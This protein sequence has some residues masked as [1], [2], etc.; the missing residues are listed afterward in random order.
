MEPFEGRVSAE[1]DVALG[2]SGR[3][4]R[5]GVL[6]AAGAA[7]LL[8]AGVLVAG[9]DRSR[10][11]EDHPVTTTSV[12]ATSRTS[13]P[14]VTITA[15]PTTTTASPP[16]PTSIAMM[17]GTGALVAGVPTGA[18]VEAFSYDGRLIHIDLD[19]GTATAAPGPGDL[20]IGDPYTIWPVTGGVVLT[21]PY[22][23]GQD[24]F[25]PGEVTDPPSPLPRS[26]NQ[27]YPAAD[28]SLLWYVQTGLGSTDEATLVRVADGS[29]VRTIQFPSFVTLLGD[30][31]N[32]K[33]LGFSPG[34]GTYLLVDGSAA[35]QRLSPNP[36]LA[37]N[38]TYLVDLSCD[39][40]LV[41]VWHRIVRATGKADASGVLDPN[42]PGFE[43]GGGRLSLSGRYAA[44]VA[45]DGSIHIIDLTTSHTEVLT[46]VTPGFG[47]VLWWTGGDVLVWVDNIGHLR[48]WQPGASGAEDL[49]GN[50]IP[51]LRSGAVRLLARPT[52]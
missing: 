49:Y 47:N 23:G 18:A 3:G 21:A 48:A 29:V 7:V 45:V 10:T 51:Q 25:V 33:L 24:W 26:G 16:V 30:D 20:P 9:R 39:S 15:A 6:V 34:G 43:I 35:P 19:R 46:G 32:G 2:G 52:T 50:G 5:R 36:V 11:A 4:R 44:T 1:H 13:S 40:S 38:A 22:G 27:V 12:V 28:P 31:G 41:C 37:W 8:I 17:M 42:R 14:P